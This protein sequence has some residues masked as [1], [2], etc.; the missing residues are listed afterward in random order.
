GRDVERVLRR[1]LR[2]NE[3]RVV[4]LLVSTITAN[5]NDIKFEEIRLAIQNGD[6]SPARLETLRQSIVDFTNNDLAPRWERMASAAHAQQA[7][8]LTARGL[9]APAWQA[10]EGRVTEWMRT[11]GTELA[12]ALSDSQH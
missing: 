4:R 9:N 10:I 7:A 8:A 12:V 11:R 1:L 3:P 5:A 6:L 2:A